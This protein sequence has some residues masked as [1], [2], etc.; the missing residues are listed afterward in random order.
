VEK[1]AKPMRGRVTEAA[2]GP[3]RLR[4]RHRPVASD[5]RPLRDRI[6][7]A[8]R[9]LFVESGVEAV[10][11]RAVAQRVGS[12]ATA[13][14]LHFEDKGA[15][16]RTLCEEDFLAFA[17]VF[18]GIVAVD[19]PHERLRLSG[20]AYARFAMEHP[21]SYRLLFMTP[22]LPSQLAGARALQRG[23]VE[24]DAYAFLL[25]TVTYGIER[26]AFDPRHRDPNLLAQTIWASV[27]G[28][29]SLDI[30]KHCDAWVEWTSL[31]A[32]VD[33]M[34]EVILRGVMR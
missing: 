20:R 6:L 32:R 10:T 13:I 18:H 4:A 1:T 23:N 31:E 25:A 9:E 21:S 12:S 28:V 24:Q 5:E 8:A 3:R 15:L 27:H 29:V 30:A 19:D 11:M 17:H 26:G 16:L 14:Y 22:G 34:L 2:R 7:E 33:T